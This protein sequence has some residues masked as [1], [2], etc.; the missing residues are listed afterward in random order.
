MN[1]ISC[2]FLELEVF[3]YGYEGIDAVKAALTAGLDRSSEAM[4]IKV[5]MHMVEVLIL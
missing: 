4:P 2:L 1:T 3:C 5:C